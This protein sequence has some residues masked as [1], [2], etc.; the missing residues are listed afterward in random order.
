[1]VFVVWLSLNGQDG[2][3]DDSKGKDFPHLEHLRKQIQAL[4]IEP[5]MVLDGEILRT[6]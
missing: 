3:I 1:M 2:A 5:N 4:E 6:R